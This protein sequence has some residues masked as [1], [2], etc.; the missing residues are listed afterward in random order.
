MLSIYLPLQCVLQ[1]LHSHWMTGRRF[2]LSFSTVGDLNRCKTFTLLKHCIA[3]SKTTRC[4]LHEAMCSSGQVVSQFGTMCIAYE[5]RIRAGKQCRRDNCGWYCKVGLHI[6]PASSGIRSLDKCLSPDPRSRMSELS[7]LVRKGTRSGTHS[8]DSIFTD[9][10]ATVLSEAC[11]PASNIATPPANLHR[12]LIMLWIMRS[13]A[14]AEHNEIASAGAEC[15][16]RDSELVG[17]FSAGQLDQIAKG[18]PT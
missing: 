12:L 18:L 4:Q 13:V 11:K 16:T 7:T 1:R 2:E 3:E 17:Q 6:S 5:C 14:Q 8:H 9:F 10:L 15:M